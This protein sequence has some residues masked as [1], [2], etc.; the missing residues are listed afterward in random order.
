MQGDTGADSNKPGRPGESA[1]SDEPVSV[2]L[3]KAALDGRTVKPGD[4]ITLTVKDVD[5]ETG[6]IEAVCDYEDTDKPGE[7]GMMDDFD[8]AVPA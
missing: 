2:F 1:N 6:D 7:G 3:S 8:K 4:T 5:S